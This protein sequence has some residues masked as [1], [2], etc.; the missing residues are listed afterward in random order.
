MHARQPLDI[1]GAIQLAGGGTGRQRRHAGLQVGARQ[2]RRQL[3]DGVELDARPGGP[4]R[5]LQEAQ[6]ALLALSL[7][8]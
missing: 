6:E 1:I 5:D 4:A 3:A 7:S 8:K 2:I